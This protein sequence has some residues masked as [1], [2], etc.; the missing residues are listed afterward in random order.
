MI[1]VYFKI[2]FILGCTYSCASLE[3]VSITEM[4]RKRGMEVSA[5][6]DKF[7][8][9]GLNFNNDYIDSLTPKLASQCSG[10]KVSGILTKHES[11]FYFLAHK[12]IVTARGVCTK[13]KRSRKS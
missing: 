11:Y 7:I 13:G 8:F 12:V 5:Q 10:G 6:V 2:I 3:S 9:L 4:P 1:K